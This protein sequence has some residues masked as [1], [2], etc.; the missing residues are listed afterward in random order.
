MTE[1]TERKPRKSGGSARR[2]A[3]R[4]AAVQA[5][6]QIDHSKASPDAVLEEFLRFRLGD[7]FDTDNDVAPHKNLFSEIVRG[8]A[9]RGSEIDEIVSAALSNKWTFDRLELILRAIMRAGV[10]ELEAR[11]DT[12]AR[13]IITEYV[14]V[15]HAFYDGQE[16]GMVNGMLDR[17]AHSVRA[18][19]FGDGSRDG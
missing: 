5:L 16:P 7:S 6:Y 3:A 4:L 8:V 18:E 9:A 10:Y 1:K 17:I 14:D 12:P 13:V 2:S 15:A 19:E 11:V